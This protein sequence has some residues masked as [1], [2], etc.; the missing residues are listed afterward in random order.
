[1]LIIEEIKI[2]VKDAL[3]RSDLKTFEKPAVAWVTI[4]DMNEANECMTPSF[5]VRR[6]FA[7]K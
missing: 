4:K 7:C 6:N 5:K 1:M 2:Q 3:L